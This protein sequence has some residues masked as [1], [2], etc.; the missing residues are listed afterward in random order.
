LV[1]WNHRGVAMALQQVME[2]EAGKQSHQRSNGKGV[3]KIHAYFL[4]DHC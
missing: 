4:T 1:P 3:I 2:Q